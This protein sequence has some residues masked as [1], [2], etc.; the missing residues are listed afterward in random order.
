[1]GVSLTFAV[2]LIAFV[3]FYSSIISEEPFLRNFV[4]MT[5]IMFGA[6][7][8]LYVLGTII[9]VWFHLTI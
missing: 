7:V 9:H 3:S 5:A 1:L 8:A 2:L 6:T 4:Q